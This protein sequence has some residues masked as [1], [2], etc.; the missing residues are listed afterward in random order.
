MLASYYLYLQA[1]AQL[2]AWVSFPLV[3]RAEW[4]NTFLKE[5]WPHLDPITGRLMQQVVQPMVREMLAEYHLT[6]FRYT[7]Q[8]IRTTSRKCML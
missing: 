8:N 2:P 3:E 6:G 5:L 4:L 1:L 7:A